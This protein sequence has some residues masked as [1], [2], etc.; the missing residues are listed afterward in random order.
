MDEVSGEIV[1]EIEVQSIAESSVAASQEVGSIS[2][3]ISNNRGSVFI[4]FSIIPT[5]IKQCESI[6]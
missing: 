1:Q 3:T 5:T 6:F 4:I 2:I